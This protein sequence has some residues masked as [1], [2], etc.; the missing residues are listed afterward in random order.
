MDS[1]TR[2]TLKEEA[3][4]SLRNYLA[5]GLDGFRVKGLDRLHALGIDTAACEAAGR[6]GIEHLIRHVVAYC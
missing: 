6:P 5:T 1:K 2:E 4:R 3:I